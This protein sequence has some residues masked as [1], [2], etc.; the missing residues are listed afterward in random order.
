M[1]LYHFYF[2]NLFT[3]LPLLAELKNRGY[4][5]TGTLRANWLKKK[6]TVPA[7]NKFVYY[8]FLCNYA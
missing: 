8:T 5:G 3:T 6:G 7:V 4:N 1:Y 2:D